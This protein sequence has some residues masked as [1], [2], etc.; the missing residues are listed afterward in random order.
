MH[1]SSLLK[2]I[3]DTIW[4]LIPLHF[5]NN[6]TYVLGA[7]FFLVAFEE[8]GVVF[9]NFNRYNQKC[10]FFLENGLSS[11]LL[12]LF[13]YIFFSVFTVWTSHFK[14]RKITCSFSFSFDIHLKKWGF[15]KSSF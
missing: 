7:I 12:G 11:L 13:E 1:N 4:F 15:R 3:N 14:G 2:F 10:N 8:Q 9:Y 5:K 6:K